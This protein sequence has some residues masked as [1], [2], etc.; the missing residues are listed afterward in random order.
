MYKYL[1]TFTHAHPIHKSILQSTHIIITLMLYVPATRKA[2]AIA[3]KVL[4]LR[5]CM[6]VCGFDLKILFCFHA[7]ETNRRALA[8]YVCVSV[9]VYETIPL[10]F[11]LSLIYLYV[12]IIC[13]CVVERA[14]ELCRRAAG[15]VPPLYITGRSRVRPHYCSRAPAAARRWG[16]VPRSLSLL[17]SQR[18]RK[19][20]RRGPRC[21][22]G[23]HL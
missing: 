7:N 9:P 1:A 10:L 21:G 18:E 20:Q 16:G 5:L 2:A 11:S 23:T 17:Q 8:L 22:R 12:Y 4:I 13:V 14:R 6:C 15:T 3:T 19:R